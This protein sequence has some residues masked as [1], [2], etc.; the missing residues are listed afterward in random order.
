MMGQRRDSGGRL[1][2]K[3]NPADD[4]SR[5]LSGVGMIP[6]IVGGKV[7]S[8]YG[9]MSLPGLPIGS[10]CQKLPVMVRK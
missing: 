6:V 8:S 2:L 3:K 5:S 4:V 7:Q 9:R 10:L 1:T